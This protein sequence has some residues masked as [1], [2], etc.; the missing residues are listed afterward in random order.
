MGVAAVNDNY[1][2]I[3]NGSYSTHGTI[4]LSHEL[5]NETMQLS[6]D[7][8]PLIQKTFTGGVMPVGVCQNW[9]EIYG[10]GAAYK[11][12]NYAEWVAGTRTISVAAPT[13]VT[14]EVPFASAAVVTSSGLPAGAASASA[15]DTVVTTA[16][17]AKVSATGSGKAAAAS[18]SGTAP[19]AAKAASGGARVKVEGAFKVG[20]AVLAGLVGGV[21]LLA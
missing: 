9:T 4:V 2:S 17:G 8:L 18:A 15:S 13:A 19:T 7:H 1:A 12:P 6:K 20:A 14:S 3:I 21:M 10:E 5:D 11:Y 16:S